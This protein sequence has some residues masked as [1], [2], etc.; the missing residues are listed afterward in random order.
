MLFAN[1]WIRNYFLSFHFRYKHI[2]GEKHY[3]I[4]LAKYNISQLYNLSNDF[5][6][7]ILKHREQYCRDVLEAVNVLKPGLSLVRGMYG[8]QYLR[9]EEI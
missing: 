5:S 9:K 3:L 6:V 7:D 4:T 1:S 2:L 8:S